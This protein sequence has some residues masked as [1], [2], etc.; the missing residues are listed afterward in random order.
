[1][2]SAARDILG[3]R[4]SPE[5]QGG[6]HV[7]RPTH[8]VHLPARAVRG[9]QLPRDRVWQGKRLPRDRVWSTTASWPTNLSGVVNNCRVW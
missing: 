9:Q 2:Y 6:A 4:L 8:C 3:A 1:M 5:R 7:A